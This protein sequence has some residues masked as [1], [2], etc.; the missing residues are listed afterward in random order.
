MKPYSGLT[1]RNRWANVVANRI[2]LPRQIAIFAAVLGCLALGTSG[3]KAQSASNITCQSNSFNSAGTDTC[4][5]NLSGAA[6]TQTPVYLYSSD[7]ALTFPGTVYVNAGASSATFSA[8]LASVSSARTVWITAQASSAMGSKVSYGIQLSAA[9]TSSS[10][11]QLSNVSC[12]TSSFSSA[13]TDTCSVNLSGATQS[14]IAVSLYSSDPAL[15]VPGTIYVNAGVSSATFSATLASV[16]SARTV[17]ITAQASSGTGSKVSYGI[18]L[19]AASTSSSQP[20]LSNVSC[21]TSSFSSAGTDACSVN[22]SGATQNQI[23]VS[24]YSSDPALTVPGTV[25]VNAGASSATFSATLASVSSARTVWITAQASSGTGSKVSYG[26]QLSAASTSSS[27]PQLSTVSCQTSSFSSAGTD[28][29]SVNL[30][31]ATQSQI[32]VNLYSSDPALTVPG[33]V[34]VNTGASSATFSATLASVS[35]AR[36]VWITA[37]ASSGTGSKV[38]YGIKLTPSSTSTQTPTLTVNATSISFGPVTVNTQSTQTVTLTS[39]GTAPVTVNSAAVTGNGFS[40]S[41]SSFPVT[42]NPGQSL[43]LNLQFAPTIAGSATGQLTVVSNSSSNPT[44]TFALSGTGTSHQV[45]LSWNPPAATSD[46]VAGYNVYRAPGGTTSYQ[47]LNSTQIGYAN[48]TDSAVTSGQTY[49]Y[50]V[51]SVDSAGVESAP[52]NTATATVP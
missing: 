22:L 4:S 13:G 5:V 17:W 3:A 43:N 29:C 38:T 23:A 41:G 20:Q 49:V 14:Q 40:V 2:Y 9:S 16:S 44:A 10:Q 32:A 18:Q 48:Y 27:Q 1:H 25:Y 50:M 30:S 6:Q 46:P 12:Q 45:D 31:G 51:K 24:L 21:Q 15:T 34:Y 19:S 35:S 36:T 28:T 7:P 37:Q 8:T 42:L 47:R 26:I 39:S 33:T 11:P 52:S